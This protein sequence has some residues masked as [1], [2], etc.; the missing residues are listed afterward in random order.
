MPETS[1]NPTFDIKFSTDIQGIP[2]DIVYHKFANKTCL[3]VTQ[4]EKINNLF[5]VSVAFDPTGSISKMP[6]IEMVHCFGTDTDE[7]QC[8]IRYIVGRVPALADSTN[9]IVINFGVREIDGVVL[10]ELVSVLS[11]NIG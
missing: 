6:N 8:G 10:D 3:F 1:S 7:I 11:S 4:Y 5:V 9:A 2:T